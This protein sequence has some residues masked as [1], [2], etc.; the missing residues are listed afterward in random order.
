MS[1]FEKVGSLAG[2]AL[3]AA[4][5][6]PALREGMQEAIEGR[7]E[8]WDGRAED[9]SPCCRG[10]G[11]VRRNVLPGD[12]DFGK[13]FDCS[14]EIGQAR[15]K[16]RQDRIWSQA[17]VPP[18]MA[19]YSLDTL[20]TRP[21]R[22]Q[23]ADELRAWRER[24]RWLVLLG[25]R[26]TCKTGAAVSLLLEHVRAGGAGL[27]IVLPSFLSRIRKTYGDRDSVDE[28]EVLDTV[29]KTPFLVLD[30]IGTATL[31]PWGQE[32]L[33]TVINERDLHHRVEEPRITVVT[34]NLTRET[35]PKHLDPEERTWDRIRGWADIV[36][37]TGP[38]QRGLDL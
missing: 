14:C 21:G 32:K 23:L 35:L 11:Y 38:S 16:K 28:D 30:D 36:E 34:S 20:A 7:A 5:L 37:L 3:G 4:A 27:Y 6:S 15:A 26:G 17:L 13:L 19:N 9:A 22:A 31:T 24:D 29:I 12:V 10:A 2:L 25:P 18:K 1:E 8:R 33:F